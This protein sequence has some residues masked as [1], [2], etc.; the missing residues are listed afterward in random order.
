MPMAR[1][2]PAAA[3][4]ALPPQLLAADLCSCGPS[5]GGDSGAAVGTNLA[6]GAIRPL[7]EKLWSDCGVPA[8]EPSEAE[9]AEVE[10]SVASRLPAA[11][12]VV[13]APGQSLPL[14][15]ARRNE[16]THSSASAFDEQSSSISLPATETIKPCCSC[17]RRGARKLSFGARRC[18]P[19]PA[20]GPL[21]TELGQSALAAG[22]SSKSSGPTPS[23]TAPDSGS[24][25]DRFRK[26][27]GT[28]A[29]LFD[30]V[31]E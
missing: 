3:P 14:A 17:D 10:M 31:W 22:P 28:E 16:A 24:S 5:I 6:T 12:A 7:S 13:A 21:F 8:R 18:A 23:I 1:L 30:S 9:P 2:P 20:R 26:G 4:L 27:T 29:V 15:I 25:R 11:A 19:L